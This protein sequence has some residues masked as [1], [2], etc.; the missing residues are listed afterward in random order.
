MSHE[1]RTPLNAILGYSEM[2]AE[3]AEASGHAD[4]VPD[5]KKIRTAGRHLLGLIN[6][7]LDLSKIEAGKMRLYLE[8][9]EVKSVVEEAAGTARP[10]VERKGNRL[11]VRCPDGLGSI[12]EDVTKVRQVLLNLLSNAGKFTENGLVTLEARREV[13]VAGNWVFFRVS[14]TGIGMTAEQTARLFEA[15]VQADAGT[16]KKY[17]GTGLG[18]A[19]TRKLCKLMGGDIEVE[20]VPGRG[21]AFSVRLPGEI[22]NFDGDATSVRL[23]TQTGLRVSP[24]PAPARERPLLLV[25][26]DDPAV[27]DLMERLC[28]R[29]G[30]EVA[31]AGDGVEGLRLA[32]EKKPDLIT[33][34]VVMPGMDGWSVLAALRADVA[35]ARTPVVVVTVVDDRDRGL[36][37]GASDYLVKP[38]DHERLLAVLESHRAGAAA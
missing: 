33:L 29:Q 22:E 32:R 7:V 27:C 25:I 9:F 30:F 11:E 12:R 31:T 38:I 34:D 3:D 1:L 37:L 20:S 24:T 21:T 17:G 8:T 36:S 14:D 16:M 23:T 28:A 10:L 15:F 18:L 26:D 6:D 19:I 5:L 13:G 2:L 35:M 4:I